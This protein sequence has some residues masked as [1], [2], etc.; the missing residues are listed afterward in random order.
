MRLNLGTSQQTAHDET[1]ETNDQIRT[2]YAAVEQ[3]ESDKLEKLRRRRTMTTQRWSIQQYIEV[4][5]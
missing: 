1:Y 2:S 5:G 4:L 3:Y